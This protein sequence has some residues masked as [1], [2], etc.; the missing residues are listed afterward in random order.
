MIRWTRVS[1][2]TVGNGLIYYAGM[3]NNAGSGTPT[4]FEGTTG[5][6]PPNN[7]E[8]HCKYLT[9]PQTNT[10]KGS[11]DAQTGVITLVLPSDLV[12]T[13]DSTQL[14]SVTAFSATSATP[15]SSTTFLNLIDSTAPFDYKV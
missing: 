9:Y 8:E 1:P 11:Y 3:D 14:Y 6:V 5:C 4:F 15:Q 10:I 7:A 12:H 2:G 13:G